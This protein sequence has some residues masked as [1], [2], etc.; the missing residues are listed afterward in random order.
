M[1]HQKMNQ[2]GK[3]LGVIGLAGLGH[4]EV[5]FGKS[6]GLKVTVF[7]TSISK[8]D[9]ALNLLGAE[10]IVVSSNEQQMSVSFHMLERKKR[11]LIKFWGCFKL[12]SVILL[13]ALA[14]FLDFILN[15]ASADMPFNPYM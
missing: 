3:S 9:E 14:K 1:M 8:K 2:P 6:F 13:Q 11:G 7:S 10:K 12:M 5:K 15:T 4:L